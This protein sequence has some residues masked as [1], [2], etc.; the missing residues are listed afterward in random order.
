M[1]ELYN[2]LKAN[3]SKL[4][5]PLT[6][7]VPSMHCSLENRKKQNRTGGGGSDSK[8]PDSS[9]LDNKRTSEETGLTAGP[10]SVGEAVKNHKSEGGEGGTVRGEGG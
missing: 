2:R 3:N 4:P 5:A 10:V 1:S 6:G 7:R 8:L 9:R